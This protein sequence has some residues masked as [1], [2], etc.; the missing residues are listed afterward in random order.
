MSA[1]PTASP[2]PNPAASADAGKG[3]GPVRAQG[4]GTHGLPGT[5]ATAHQGGP[6]AR[7]IVTPEG[8]LLPVQLAPRGERAVALIID[9]MIIIA[10]YVGLWLLARFVIAPLVAS[11]FGNDGVR[12][13]SAIFR[14]LSFFIFSFYFA[15]F[16]LRWQGQTPAKHF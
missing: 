1:G 2:R 15:F 7:S 14:I 4:V 13:V 16:E 3:A 9:V 8:V 11:G 6:L 5:I 10:A 12:I